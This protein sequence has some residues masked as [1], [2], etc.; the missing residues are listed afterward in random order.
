MAF[1]VADRVRESSASTGITTF[2]LT[3]AALGYQTFL[4]AIGNGNSTYYVIS[5]LGVNEWEV[6]IGTVSAST[7]QRTTVL[8]SS[9]AGALVDFTAGSKDVFVTYPAEVAVFAGNAVTLTNKTISGADNT[10][11]NIG[12]SSLTNSSLTVGTTNIALGAT[13]LTLAG[14]TSV[15]ATTFNGAL[16]GNATTATTA[17]NLAGGAASQIPYQSGSGATAFLA[18]GT[19]GQVLTSNGA[20]APS[21]GSNTITIGSTGIALGATSTTLAGLTSITT[22]GMTVSGLTSGRLTYATT[23]GAL[24]D[25]SN[26]TWNGTTLGVTGVLTVSQDSTFSSTGALKISSG[27]TLQQPGAPAV[28]MMRY[29]TT[30]NQFEGYSGA[31]PAWKSIG[32]SALSND[33]ATASALYPVF[34]AATT[35]TAENLY[36]SNAKYLYT[37]STGELQAAEMLANNGIG[38][39]NQTVSA[40]YTI[41][42]SNNAMS[43]GPVAIASGATV[44]VSSGSIWYIA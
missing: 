12:N 4:A 43:V 32:G 1:L 33:T 36:T 35:G 42:A 40:S 38:L 34:A 10:L 7:L 25:S 3:G 24:T 22:V 13:S 19:S 26:L 27:T 23:G 15:T 11:S 5:N 30:T 16:S 8:A 18:N 6:G 29:N 31:S 2:T 17:T 44:T 20:T 9:N 21:W 39:N 28:G 14:L 37:P 41:A